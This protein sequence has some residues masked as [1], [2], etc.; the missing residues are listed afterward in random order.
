[1]ATI[2]KTFE[3]ISEFDNGA[4]RILQRIEQEWKQSE[5][6]KNKNFPGT[7]FSY[8]LNKM[9]K[10]SQSVMSHYREDVEELSIEHAAVDDKGILI[11]DERG[12]FKYKPDELKK[13]NKKQYEKFRSQTEIEPHI[14]K[15]ESIPPELRP[16]EL[17]VLADFVIQAGTNGADE[18]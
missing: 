9:L 11:V 5:E 15:A 12:Q 17:D 10:R 13:R 16:E 18:S 6:N 14:V 1:M 4:R 8:A 3:Q 7:K 2:K